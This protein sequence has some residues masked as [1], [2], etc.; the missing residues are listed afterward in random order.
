[1]EDVL[2]RPHTGSGWENTAWLIT[3]TVL[4]FVTKISPFSFNSNIQSSSRCFLCTADGTAWNMLYRSSPSSSPYYLIYYIFVQLQVA[5][6]S[7]SSCSTRH[8]IL[9]RTQK[10]RLQI[11]RLICASN[12]RFPAIPAA[13]SRRYTLRFS[14]FSGSILYKLV[15]MMKI[16]SDTTTSDIYTTSSVAITW[17]WWSLSTYIHGLDMAT[18]SLQTSS[19]TPIHCCIML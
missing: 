16:Y 12:K 8:R 4:I 13:K 19:A 7:S 14:K 11:R 1:M 2:S 18:P 15:G 3:R 17:W 6:Y 5:I 9:V 10:D